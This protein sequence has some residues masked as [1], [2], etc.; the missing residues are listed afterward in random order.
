MNNNCS[1]KSFSKIKKYCNYFSIN[2]YS[3]KQV[4]IW[5]LCWIQ[6]L[7]EECVLVQRA[8]KIS[9]N[10]IK[11]LY[12]DKDYHRN[13]IKYDNEIKDKNCSH[14]DIIPFDIYVSK[15]QDDINLLMTTVT[16]RIIYMNKIDKIIYLIS[17]ILY[18]ESEDIIYISRWIRIPV[19]IFVKAINRHNLWVKNRK[20]K[21]LK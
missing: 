5:E 4:F 8:I 14:K 20:N 12:S 9:S 16:F 18:E 2:I 21:Q 10:V 15:F 19:K 13:K 3:W 11:R 1:N 7:K 6:W 17:K